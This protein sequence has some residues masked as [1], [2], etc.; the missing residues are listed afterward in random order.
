MLS[1]VA[2]SDCAS[3]KLVP[4]SLSVTAEAGS[5]LKL[6]AALVSR[7]FTDTPST[8]SFTRIGASGFAVSRANVTLAL[9]V[10]S[11]LPDMS[12]T[13]SLIDT[14]KSSVELSGA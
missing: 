7:S 4:V 8:S 1:Q 11:A 3:A 12:V 6:N 14:T 5:A 2:T 10:S 13:V 9:V